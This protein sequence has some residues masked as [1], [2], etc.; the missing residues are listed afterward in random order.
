MIT[1]SIITS[2]Y[3]III[4]IAMTSTIIIGPDSFMRGKMYIRN[5]CLKWCVGL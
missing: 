3:I 5:N 1:P 2:I 4:T